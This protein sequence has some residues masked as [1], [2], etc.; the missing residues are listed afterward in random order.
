MQNPSALDLA[1]RIDPFVR[2]ILD[3]LIV[4][5]AIATITMALLELA[6]ALFRLRYLF[7]K[8]CVTTWVGNPF[9]LNELLILSASDVQTAGALLDQPTDKMMGQIQSAANV[10]VDFPDLYSNFYS[11]LTRVPRSE[12]AARI[13]GGITTP[14]SGT[15]DSDVWRNFI[16][17]ASPTPSE[18][19]GPDEEVVAATRARARIDHFI[20]RKLDAFQTRT[21]YLWAR[22]NQAISVAGAAVFI[23]VLLRSPS[24]TG[25]YVPSVARAIFLSI[26]GGMIAPFAKDVVAALSGL[27]A[28]R[29]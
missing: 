23:F 9:T 1:N 15:P 3:Y 7:H 8:W 27:R 10:A 5:A 28:R 17:K 14:E 2:Y 25:V 4:I 21:E 29:S 11:F 26:F 19:S 6:K 24:T 13:A 18:Q 12:A 16:T 22:A 20:T